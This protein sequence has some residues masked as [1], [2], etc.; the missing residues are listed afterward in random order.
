M[1]QQPLWMPKGSVRAILAIL[2]TSAA[3]YG[4]LFVGLTEAGL[5]GILSIK[6]IDDY[7]RARQ[8]GM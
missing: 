3:I 1:E 4:A 7:F 5:L 2:L 8:N 6:V